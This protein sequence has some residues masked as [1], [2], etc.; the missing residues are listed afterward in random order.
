MKI[1]MILHLTTVITHADGKDSWHIMDGAFSRMINT[2]AL[3]PVGQPLFLDDEKGNKIYRGVNY[4]ME[5]PEITLKKI[6]S[7]LRRGVLDYEAYYVQKVCVS[8]DSKIFDSLPQYRYYPNLEKVEREYL[9]TEI[10]PR[11]E[12]QGFI[13][14]D[15]KF[16]SEDAE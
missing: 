7:V 15:P 1:K 9:R 12:A 5:V 3:P 2:N 13:Y 6:R 10:W 14:D 8:I 4:G 16:I 11:L